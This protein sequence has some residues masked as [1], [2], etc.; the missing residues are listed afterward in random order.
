MSL[1]PI[2]PHD[3]FTFDVRPVLNMLDMHH[4]GVC[5]MNRYQADNNINPDYAMYIPLG[6]VTDQKLVAYRA[7][8]ID[9]FI[10][11]AIN[12]FEHTWIQRDLSRMT[13][14]EI[15]CFGEMTPAWHALFRC[16]TLKPEYAGS[17]AHY[18]RINDSIFLAI[19]KY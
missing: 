17:F 19:P 14:L 3:L 4:I 8:V 5:A 11:T 13:P 15:R 7:Q 12:S 18:Q 2:P 10:A 9:D 16:I 1:V 6:S